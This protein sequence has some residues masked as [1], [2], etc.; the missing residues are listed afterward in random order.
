MTGNQIKIF[1]LLLLGKN[2]AGKSQLMKSI[3]N[4]LE[5]RD[6]KNNIKIE[7]QPKKIIAVSTSPFDKFPLTYGYPG[8][9]YTYLGLRD[10][11]SR[12]FGKEYMTNIYMSLLNSM[13]SNFYRSNKIFEVLGF[14]NYSPRIKATF[15]LEFFTKRIKDTLISNDPIESFSQSILLDDTLSDNKV[16]TNGFFDGNR[17]VDPSKVERYIDIYKKISPSNI[18]SRI[19]VLLD[20]GGFSLL[21]NKTFSMED[22]FFLEEIKAVKLRDITLEKVS[23][24]CFCIGGASSGEQSVILNML[25]IASQIC[26][27]SLI[28]IDEPEVC[29]HP[30][31]QEKYIDIMINT[32]KNFKGCHFLIATHSPL[33]VSK[34]K[35]V[36]C[37]LMKMESGIAINAS[38]I[39]N[40]SADFQLA[41][42]F[43][44][45]G[46]K[47]EY[48]TREL[49]SILSL[50]GKEGE[51]DDAT[52]EK[53]KTLLS[54]KEKISDSDPVFELMNIAQEVLQ[55]NL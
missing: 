38:K 15:N 19:E 27:D 35:D 51:L 2:G 46:F 30:E 22:L 18:Q 34:L 54:L 14:L 12:N 6:K 32:F 11:K 21:N 55:E 53:L 25:G 16:R 52:Q 40:R 33:M 39:N 48:L 24:E 13:T 50:F 28:C 10:L 4:S 17:N 7:K 47:N 20:E 8:K 44:A 36:N 1:S 45:P 37:Y 41:N 3:I 23:G 29:L 5:Y 26:D 43:G 49:I 31:W 9:R 42:T